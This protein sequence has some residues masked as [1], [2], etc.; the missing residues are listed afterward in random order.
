MAAGKEVT[1]MGTGMVT[2]LA[3]DHSVVRKDTT[4]NRHMEDSNITDLVTDHIKVR[5]LVQEIHPIWIL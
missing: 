1:K 3:L 2:E 5:N 4:D